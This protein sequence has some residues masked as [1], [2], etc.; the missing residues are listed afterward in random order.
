MTE[1]HGV[2]GDGID[3]GR[4]NLILF[5]LLVEFALVFLLVEF[6]EVN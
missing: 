6:A 4:L 3:E 5:F 2:Y 1:M